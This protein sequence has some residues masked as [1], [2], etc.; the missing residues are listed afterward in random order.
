MAVQFSSTKRLIF[1][2]VAIASVVAV[3]NLWGDNDDSSYY[4]ALAIACC[5][6]LYAAFYGA[7]LGSLHILSLSDLGA[8]SKGYL[9]SGSAASTMSSREL[10]VVSVG[11]ALGA[12][13]FVLHLT[14]QEA[15]WLRY[16]AYALTVAMSMTMAND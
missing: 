13:L 10:R 4:V 5:A 9:V 16:S 14:N 8:R 3:G 1:G 6:M 7:K 15:T 11:S 2:T 12:F